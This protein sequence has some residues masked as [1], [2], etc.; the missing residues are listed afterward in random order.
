MPRVYMMSGCNG[1]G[2]ATCSYSLLPELLECRQ[3]V[4]SDEFAK[5]LSPF[6]PGAA[7]IKAGRLM[8]RKVMYLMARNQT[9]SIETTLATRALVKIVQR[10]QARGYEVTI[11]YFWLSSPQKAIE[12]V[13]SRV[14]AG[15]H[16]IPEEVIKRRYYMGLDYLFNYY[17]PVCDHWI[18]A[19]N[20]KPPFR[21]LAQG[22]KG[23]EPIIRDI[24]TY[25]IVKT[26]TDSAQKLSEQNST[27]SE[28]EAQE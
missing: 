27:V 21:V 7:S 15:G 16:D 18:L 9:F 13:R 23:E 24:K 20:S 14:R 8:M 4:N 28:K 17:I 19:D 6:N 1:S 25:G 2:K 26:L 3:F 22:N 10:A 5:A 11:L 12:R